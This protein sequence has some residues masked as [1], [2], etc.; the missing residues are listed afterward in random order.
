VGEPV[1][2]EA[3]TGLGA[4]ASFVALPKPEPAIATPDRRVR[5]FVSSTLTEL[6]A[7]RMAARTAITRMHLTPVMF[8]VGARTHPARELY[9]AYLT[10]SDVFVGI[11]GQQ[12]GWVAP[13][14]TVSGL[15]DEYLRSGER[16]KLIYVKA[17]SERDPRLQNLL[18]RIK[19]DDGVSYKHFRDPEDLVELIADDLAVLL[20]ET[21]ARGD[22]AVRG[23]LRPAAPPVAVTG[24]VGREGEIADVLGLLRDPTV[25]LVSLI[26][27]GGIGKTR[28]AMELARLLEDGVPADFDGVSFVDLSGVRDAGLWPNAVGSILG[29]RPEGNHS[30]LDLLIDRM[31]GRRQLLVLDNF[32]QLVA[33][34]AELSRLL[35]AC[36]DLTVLVTSR[37]VLRLRGEREVSLLPLPIPATSAP[38]DV[39][40]ISQSPAVRLLVARAQQVHPGFDVTSTNVA[41]IAELCR[42]LEGIPLALELAAAQLRLLTP[43]SL[44]R[45]L[46]QTLDRSLDL[47][48]TTVDSPS[49]QRTLRA[50]I[51]WSHSLLTEAE[52]A[53]LARLSVFT[54]AWT[55]EAT[56]A[57]GTSDGDLDALDT[58]ASL[59]AQSLVRTDESDPDEPRFRMLE[60][61]RTYAAERLAE[62]GEVNATHRRL[63]NYLL[64]VVAKLRDGLQGPHHRGAAERLDREQD[65]LKSAIA[66]A[67]S[68]DDAETVGR[69]I[70]PLFTYWWSRGLLPMTHQMTE[71]AALLPSAGRLAPYEAALL[72]GARGMSMVMVGL[73]EQAEPLLRR[74]VEL[75][76][77]LGNRR[78]EAYGLLGLAWALVPSTLGEATKRLD[79]AADGFRE[80]GDSWGLALT[81]TTRGQ[82]HLLDGDCVTARLL[83]L[84]ALAAAEAIDNDHLKAQIL[85]MLGLDAV[86]AGDLTGARERYADAAA[87]HSSLLDYEGSAYGLSGLAGLALAQGRPEAA[88]RLMGASAH[89][90]KVVGVI[91]WPGMQAMETGRGESA[92]ADIGVA[93]FDAAYL[94]GAKMHIAEAFAYGL[95]ATTFAAEPASPDAVALSGTAI[96]P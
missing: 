16:P 83:H 25:H 59:V 33:G 53:L 84:D 29:I 72:L 28:L 82:L 77:E 7:D 36:Q 90:R 80:T 73:T 61:L 79:D 43:A 67:L 11:Y 1:R 66:W 60:T 68:V 22:A 13:N 54:G 51:E 69:I 10:Q 91:L 23:D 35:S 32:E 92:A 88:S 78:L 15:E 40:T 34:A 42:R 62:R 4:R 27:P 48:A 70:T 12:Y 81:L 17:G 21:F 94:E 8:E 5:V 2:A 45:R 41:A 57:V 71:K 44:V 50:T 63:A 6:A 39:E 96:S 31:Q 76:A 47:A 19:A 24:I 56:D 52:R 86:A 49:R 55:F 20:T 26:G 14:E 93:R 75:S 3:S 85:D 46:G 87:L 89:A 65:E 18:A 30:V 38:L 64:D 37:I 9:R 95:R 74:T 58:L